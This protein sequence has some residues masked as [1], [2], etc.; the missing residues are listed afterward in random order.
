[1]MIDDVDNIVT[2]SGVYFKDQISKTG[3]GLKLQR[4]M[5]SWDNHLVERCVPA[6]LPRLL[7]DAG[8][9]CHES[10][11]V[12]FTDTCLRQDGMA[13]M[14]I[15]LMSAYA[16]KHGHLPADEVDAWS[17]DLRSLAEDGRFFFSLTHYV[18]VA[19]KV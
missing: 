12:T 10:R 8:F 6:L 2:P 4:M 7:S 18:T 3:S 14:M 16:K 1:M 9:S 19:H 15:Y 13:Q 17:Q 11:P 5:T